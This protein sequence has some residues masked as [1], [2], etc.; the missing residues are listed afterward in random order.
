MTMPRSKQN[1]ANI[2][3]IAM[4]NKL[5]KIPLPMFTK[6]LQETLTYK[7]DTSLQDLKKRFAKFFNIGKQVMQLLVSL[8]DLVPPFDPS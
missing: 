3:L 4:D 2:L 6:F 5:I 1:I 8:S 7:F